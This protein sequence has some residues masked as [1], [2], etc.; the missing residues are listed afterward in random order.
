[1]PAH[2]EIIDLVASLKAKGEAFVLATVVRTVSVTAAKAG[3]KAVI[4]AD[5][6]ISDGWIGGGCARAAVLKAAREA[7]ADGHPRLVSIQPR[8]LLAEQGLR[9]GEERNGIRFA[10]NACPSQGTMDVFVE[11]MLPRPVLVVMGASPVAVALAELAPRFG[12]QLTVCAAPEDQHLFAESDRRVEGFALPPSNEPPSNE[13]PGTIVVSTQGRDD[14]AALKA[15][16]MSSAEHIAFVG[17]RRKLAA[18][19]E[20][21]LAEGIAAERIARVKGPAGLDIGAITADEIALSILAEMISQRRK[22]E[23]SSIA[24]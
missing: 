19:S 9:P 13:P 16:V 22:A 10:R 5:G 11:P 4:R 1:M 2:P 17:S 24:Q 8:D 3:A 23:R 15:A 12:Y 20:A 18:I 6:A 7:L 21:L 14:E